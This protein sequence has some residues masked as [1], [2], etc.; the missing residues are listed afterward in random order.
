MPTEKRSQ[1]ILALLALELVFLFLEG[2]RE[3][4]VISPQFRQGLL[5][6]QNVFVCA[7]TFERHSDSAR[8][9]S[10]VAFFSSPINAFLALAY[11]DTVRSISQSNA[12]ILAASAAAGNPIMKTMKLTTAAA[13]VLAVT[14]PDV[15][16]A[17]DNAAGLMVDGA[18]G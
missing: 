10:A 9:T 17:A 13:P 1:L 14:N 12:N 5:L 16:A 4:L 11:G 8:A 18:T 7:T 2:L 3:C 15:R 6:S